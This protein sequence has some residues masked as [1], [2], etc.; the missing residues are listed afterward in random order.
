[1]DERADHMRIDVGRDGPYYVSGGVPLERAEI[2]TNAQGESVAWHRTEQL[3]AAEAYSLCR[4]GRSCTKPYCDLSHLD[5]FDGEETAEHDTYFQTAQIVP[6]PAMDLLDARKLCAE[7]RFC[8]RAGGLWNLIE[9]CDEP[10]IAALVDEEAA[11]CPSGR[12]TTT[13]HETREPH[14]PELEASIALVEDPK[15][16]VAGPLWVQGGILVVAVDGDPYE[17]RNR[18]TLC[19]CG[20]SKNKP[21]CDGSHISAGFR[22]QD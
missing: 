22:D 14:E 18:V 15:Y 3:D 6:G 19:R 10:E 7:A 16:G 1:M 17:V 2:A 5:G 21:F 13:D 12:Y 11:L 20:A 8:D 9:R 4:C